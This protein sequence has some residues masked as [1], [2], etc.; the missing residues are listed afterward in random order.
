MTSIA[1]EKISENKWGHLYRVSLLDKNKIRP[2][3]LILKN[4]KSIFGLEKIYN[5]SYI[6]WN[7][8]KNDIDIVK[9]LEKILEESYPNSDLEKLVS[10]ISIRSNYP[11][12]LKTKIS[13]SS[14]HDVIKHNQGEIIT[15]NDLKNKLCNVSLLLKV[16]N[17]NNKK[18]TYNLEIKEIALLNNN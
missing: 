18:L 11:T 17:I 2:I 12:M 15:Y 8:S 14:S 6:K 5:K 9:L 7:I 10:Q 1:Y 3:E 13:N 4:V 16:V